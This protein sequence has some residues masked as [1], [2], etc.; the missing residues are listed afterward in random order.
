MHYAVQNIKWWL[1]LK[2]AV[3]YNMSRKKEE[4]AE[5]G[6]RGFLLQLRWQLCSQ[7]VGTGREVDL[8][9]K[10]KISQFSDP[11]YGHTA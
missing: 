2:D 9:L 6:V 8:R 11:F 1:P 5:D 10:E 7:V 4:L 3:E